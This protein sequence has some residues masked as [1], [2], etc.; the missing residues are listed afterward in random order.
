MNNLN[1]IKKLKK[2]KVESNSIQLYDYQHEKLNEMIEID[3]YFETP[4]FFGSMLL[5][6]ILFG[7]SF[8][9][10]CFFRSCFF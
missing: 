7:R 9:C 3:S 8:F 10:R 5:N 2:N 1:R 6:R 4:E